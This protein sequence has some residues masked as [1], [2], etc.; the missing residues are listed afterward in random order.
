V[1]RG[2]LKTRRRSHHPPRPFGAAPQ[3]RR[4]PNRRGHMAHGAADAVSAARLTAALR[5]AC[6]PVLH[7][8]YAD[9]TDGHAVQGAVDG[10]AIRADGR[11]I[12]AL[13]VSSCFEGQDALQRQQLVNRILGPHVISGRLHSVQL[14]CWTPAQWEKQGRPQNLGQPCFEQPGSPTLAPLSG[15]VGEP[16]ALQSCTAGPQP[17]L[18]QVPPAQPPP[19]PPF[20]PLP[21]QTPPSASQREPDQSQR[22]ITAE[23]IVAHLQS[24]GET[25]L[26]SAQ[27]ILSCDHA[28]DVARRAAALVVEAAAQCPVHGAPALPNPPPRVEPACTVPG[29]MN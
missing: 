28:S 6:A 8:C 9:C 26:A 10:R 21:P 24:Q 29:C 16:L 3:P 14:R 7:L 5:E 12:K 18:T 1:L 15:D 17:P 4:S 11:D 25:G 23:M 22:E 20:Q 19:Q 27:N 2:E 13:V